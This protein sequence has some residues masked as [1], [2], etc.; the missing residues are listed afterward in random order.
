MLLLKALSM[1]LKFHQ[2]ICRKWNRRLP[3]GEQ[4]C[5]FNNSEQ[6]LAFTVEQE[7]W[8]RK[9]QVQFFFCVVGFVSAIVRSDT[10]VEWFAHLFWDPSAVPTHWCMKVRCHCLM[11][12]SLPHGLPLDV[13]PMCNFCTYIK[14]ATGV[15]LDAFQA[16]LWPTCWRAEG[17]FYMT[18]SSSP[19]PLTIPL[20]KHYT[21]FTTTHFTVLKQKLWDERKTLDCSATHTHTHTLS[22]SV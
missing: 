21:Y 2:I 8:T 13:S 15:V 18:N 19:S 20:P 10:K 1:S 4:H 5:T 6:A 11:S 3:F 14:N 17:I 16:K 12:E 7:S 22:V 9:T